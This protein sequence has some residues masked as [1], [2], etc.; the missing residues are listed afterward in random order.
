MTAT[1]H[2]RLL[3]IT[4]ELALGGYT[5][6][7]GVFYRRLA[8][9]LFEVGWDVVAWSPSRDDNPGHE[10][11]A[12]H[13][14][15]KNWRSR[16]WRV[17]RV[18][19]AAAS[20]WAASIEAGLRLRGRKSGFTVVVTPDYGGWGYWIKRLNPLVPVAVRLH[21]APGLL[22][23]FTG[24]RHRWFRDGLADRLELASLRVADALV[25]P[26]S[27]MADRAAEFYGVPRKGIGVIGN[28][29][30]YE[31]SGNVD[32][33]GKEKMVLVVGRVERTKGAHLIPR[34]VKEMAKIGCRF[35][36]CLVG[37]DTA[38]GQGG[39]S[40]LQEIMSKLGGNLADK[41][42][43]HKHMAHDQLR[44]LYSKA[45]VVLV[46]S[47]FESFSNVTLEG[48][49]HRCL[50]VANENTAAADIV[51]RSK[52]GAVCRVSDAA[53]TGRIL[54]Q[55]LGSYPKASAKA[56][57]SRRKTLA[58]FSLNRV[59]ACYDEFFDRLRRTSQER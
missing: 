5:G 15:L 57:A 7:I 27:F 36:F 52:H 37:N 54:M 24:Q 8:T 43:Y 34:L 53:S 58:E 25:A 6:G 23:K 18:V 14:P 47:L 30:P 44:E 41:I 9:G 35:R 33:R 55:L 13:E 59:M 38:S 39:T 10:T 49:Q 51:R 26:S 3:I 16:L 19:G 2:K 20:S 32:M 29:V 46:P 48:L 17:S 22:R 50:V 45:M 31:T 12:W 56:D 28:P 4:P 21:A 40:M 42:E 1:P 11:P